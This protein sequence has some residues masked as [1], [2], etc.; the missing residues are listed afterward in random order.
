MSH[1]FSHVT[2]AVLTSLS[3]LD[4]HR[5][6]DIWIGLPDGPGGRFRVLNRLRSTPR[7][8]VRL[9]G[10]TACSL[11]EQ[12]SETVLNPQK[13]SSAIR[14][15]D[16]PEGSYIWLDYDVG[17]IEEGRT[18]VSRPLRL[19]VMATEAKEGRARQT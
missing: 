5:V 17:T 1:R 8:A 3:E 9:A 19:L 14:I 10:Q 16:G 13:S 7:E 6:S 4:D 15:S 18:R 2:D 11:A 12:S